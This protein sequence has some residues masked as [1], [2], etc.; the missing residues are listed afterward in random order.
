[1]TPRSF[2][3]PL[4]GIADEAADDIQ[5][6]IAAHLEL[7]WPC[8]ELRQIGGRQAS[9]A[10]LPEDEFESAIAAIEDAGLRVSGFASAIGNWSRPIQGDF[11]L[12]LSDARLLGKRMERAGA[13]FVRTMSWVG[14]GVSAEFWRDEGVRRYKELAK[15]AADS[16]FILLHENCEGWGGLSGTHMREFLERID[17]PSVGVLFDI[18]NTVAYGLDPLAYYR[19]V[20]PLIRYVHVKDCRRNP[21]GGKSVEYTLPGGGDACV[22]EI[23]GDLIASGYQEGVSI[24]PHVASIIHLGGSQASPE[25]RRSSYLQYGRA[26]EALLTDLGNGRPLE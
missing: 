19:E 18:G 12:D 16:G 6:Q 2:P 8:L 11:E 4:S 21:A 23:L 20:K 9:T 7:G 3:F 15:I 25:Y 17:H 24:E 14:E 13:K 5:G 10:L 22:R 26:L 1:M